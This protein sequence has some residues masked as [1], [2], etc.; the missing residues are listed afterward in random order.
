MSRQ[1]Y[2][3]APPAHQAVEDGLDSVYHMPVIKAP[4]MHYQYGN[5]FAAA[6]RMNATHL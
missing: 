6:H 3:D 5:T 4:T 2:V 1:I